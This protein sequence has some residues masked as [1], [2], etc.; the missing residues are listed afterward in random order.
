[1]LAVLHLRRLQ[2]ALERNR[3]DQQRASLEEVPES[4]QSRMTFV[5]LAQIFRQCVLNEV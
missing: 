3:L 5:E 4:T 2:R 1:M